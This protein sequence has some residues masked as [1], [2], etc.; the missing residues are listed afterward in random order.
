MGFLI[1]AAGLAVLLVPMLLS[2]WNQ[3]EAEKSILAYTEAVDGKSAEEM[4]AAAEEYNGAIPA[5]TCVI[6]EHN[7]EKDPAYENLLSLSGNVMGYIE[8]PDIALKLPVYHYSDEE[9]LR[10]GAGHVHGS[11]L[12]V[13][14]A[15]TNCVLTGH[16]GLPGSLLFTRL[17]E[18]SE[19]DEIYLHVL[20]RDLAYRVTEI[21][22]VLPDEVSEIKTRADKDLVTLVTCT[23]FGLNTRRL[24]ITAERTQYHARDEITGGETVKAS[25]R[26]ALTV[27]VS[28]TVIIMLVLLAAHR[29]KKNGRQKDSNGKAD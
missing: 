3:Y 27:A 29:R 17:D 25:A 23:P 7:A 16:R 1:I 4:L 10:K 26:G 2:I 15:G 28:G 9:A 19:G 21:R 20:T 18:V 5:G 12:P 6:N 8:I 22:T 14:G 11:S 24:V 13:G